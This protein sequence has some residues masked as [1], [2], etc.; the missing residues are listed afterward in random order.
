MKTIKNRLQFKKQTI[1]LLTTIRAGAQNQ[2][3]TKSVGHVGGFSAH[4]PRQTEDCSAACG[5]NNCDGGVSI[6][7]LPLNQ[8]QQQ[9]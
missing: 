7:I 4:C 2:P 5:S 3:T 6:G 8:E 1:A 9:Y